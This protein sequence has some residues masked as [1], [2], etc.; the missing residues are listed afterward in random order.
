[1]ANFKPLKNYL[2]VL[3]DD[4]INEYNA[5]GPFLD[6]GCGVGD[7]TAHLA[8]QGWSGTAIDIS[9]TAIKAARANL[10]NYPQ[11]N[12]EQKPASAIQDKFSTVLACDII[13]HV[14]DDNALMSQLSHLTVPNGKLII[15]TP[16]FM[17]EW[18][19]D[20]E[21]YGHVRRYEIPKLINLLHRH[22]FRVL[23]IWDFTFPVFWLIR[24]IYTH[25]IPKKFIIPDKKSNTLKSATNNAWDY[26]L[27]TTLFT[28]I[29]YWR[30]IFW[31][32]KRFRNHLAGCECVLIA[33]RVD[34]NS[35]DK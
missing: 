16:I 11:I 14:D 5:Q 30:P 22:N 31:L 3:I 10:Q 1:M 26:G 8:Q 34:S 19:W 12:I 13:E 4:L 21:F 18:R 17:S 35:K 24:R 20:D 2:L 27:L 15:S 33:Q 29:I 28:K 7:I 6:V 9:P 32:Q 25:L 23:A